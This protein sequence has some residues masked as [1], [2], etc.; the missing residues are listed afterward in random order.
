MSSRCCSDCPRESTTSSGISR[1][2]RACKKYRECWKKRQILWQRVQD[3]DL[4]S[5]KAKS[6]H[7]QRREPENKPKDGSVSF[8]GFSFN[9]CLFETFLKKVTD[10]CRSLCSSQH[11]QGYPSDRATRHVLTVPPDRPHRLSAHRW[12]TFS[13]LKRIES[14][15]LTRDGYSTCERFRVRGRRAKVPGRRLFLVCTTDGLGSYCI[16]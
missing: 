10:V 1:H 8:S 11:R 12:V 6:L 15:A 16:P 3:A 5:R 14:P 9:S 2:R 13:A 4:K 7:A